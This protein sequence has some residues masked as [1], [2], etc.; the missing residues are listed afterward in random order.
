MPLT[1]TQGGILVVQ[2]HL[3]RIPTRIWTPPPP[4]VVTP[5]KELLVSERSKVEVRE[6]Y[7]Q[8]VIGQWDIGSGVSYL[9]GDVL[10]A[11]IPEALE[12]KRDGQNVEIHWVSSEADDRAL[13]QLRAYYKWEKESDQ[14]SELD[15]W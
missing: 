7:Y 4:V 5:R 15:G 13:A 12:R 6:R 9:R 10:Y 3:T 2:R 11:S 14:L 8:K 1:I